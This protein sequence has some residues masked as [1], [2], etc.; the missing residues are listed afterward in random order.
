MV[1]SR[2]PNL[3]DYAVEV[4]DKRHTELPHVGRYFPLELTRRSRYVADDTY[5]EQ[6]G[7]EAL[8]GVARPR[9]TAKLSKLVVERGTGPGSDVHGL[10]QRGVAIHPKLIDYDG[11]DVWCNAFYGDRGSY[12]DLHHGDVSMRN[13]KFLISRISDAALTGERDLE[14]ERQCAR[15]KS[16][17][18]TL[19]NG[20]A[21]NRAKFT[22]FSR[23]FTSARVLHSI[24][25]TLQ[26]LLR[27][28]DTFVDFA[29]GLNSFAPLLKDPGTDAPL[30]AISYDILSP[31]ERTEGF[32]RQPWASVDAMSLPAGEL[33]IGLNPPFGHKNKEAIEFVAH[34]AECFAPRLLVLI[35]PATNYHPPGYRLIVH[36]DQLCRGSVFYA[37]GSNASNWINAN[38]QSPSVLIYEREAPTRRRLGRCQHVLSMLERVRRF[39]RQRD[40]TT[41]R[42]RMSSAKR[43]RREATFLD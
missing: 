10:L 1:L 41:A 9:L 38:K 27:P 14:A 6:Q 31:A 36:D 11:V 34:A 17:A 15:L 37:P 16:T 25:Q 2:N 18:R 30:E 42:E 21:L 32:H 7:S 5:D 19:L 8:Q 20:L 4:S 40:Q 3:R 33:I 29:C 12:N 23:H 28:G 35:M 26:P 22:S 13:I 43:Q 39:K 24:A